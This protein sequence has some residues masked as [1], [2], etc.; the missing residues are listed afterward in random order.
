MTIQIM[1]P[2]GT[3]AGSRR[4]QEQVLETLNGRKAGFIFN[5]HASGLAFWKSLEQEVERRY[6][7]AS[8]HRV[9]KENTWA[10]APTAD[11]DRLAGETDYVL[12]GLGA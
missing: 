6:K 12:V 10:P 7:P 8:M 5:Q 11:V 2:T 4:A 3:I 9:Y 1:D